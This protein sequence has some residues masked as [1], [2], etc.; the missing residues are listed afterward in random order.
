MRVV[1]VGISVPRD[2]EVAVGD[3]E[4]VEGKVDL[5]ESSTVVY[6]VSLCETTLAEE[7]GTRENVPWTEQTV[8]LYS[9]L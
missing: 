3:A 6:E 1:V 4:D 8:K 5:V 9:M 2:N 7:G